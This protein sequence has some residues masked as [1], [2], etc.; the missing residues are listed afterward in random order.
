MKKWNGWGEDGVEKKIPDNASAVLRTLCGPGNPTPDIL[1]EDLVKRIPPS[2]I[3]QKDPCILV[4]AETRFHF[5]HGQSFPDW[6][7]MRTG[8]PARQITEGVAFP[9]TEDDIRHFIQLSK[10]P[11][12]VLIPYGGGSSVVGH[13]TPLETGRAC[14]TLSMSRMNRLLDLNEENHTATFQAGVLGPD[15]EAQLRGKGFTLGHFPQ[16]FEFS[17]LGGWIA[18]RSSGQQ[19]RCFGRMDQNFLGGTLLMDDTTLTLPHI[20]AS[21]AGP[22]IRHL[23][24]GSEGRMGILS[25]ATIRIRSIPETDR[26][27]A[28]FFPDLS[29]GLEA[30][31]HLAQ[32]PSSMSMLRLSNAA[33]TQT[34][35]ALSGKVVAEKWLKT[36][37]QLRGQDPR[38]SCLC[39]VGLTG[40][41]QRV[42]SDLS[43]IKKEARRHKGLYLHRSFEKKWKENRFLSAYARNTLWDLGYGVDT[44]ETALPWGRIAEAIPLVEQSIKQVD[45]AGIHVFTHL[46][47]VYETGSSMYTTYIF[48]LK[49]TPQAT[50]EK[51]SAM[52]SSASRTI[53]EL[54][55]TISHQHGVGTD[56]AP[57][58]TPEKDQKGM[59][60]LRS[61]FHEVD[62][63]SR[64]NPGKL[65][66]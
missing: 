54:G 4:D 2:R 13:L 20:P 50:L 52:K 43:R 49:E 59:D 29:S 51:W 1:I 33:E 39:L 26:V 17:S 6:V 14:M 18:T 12:W 55:G 63:E 8:Y 35:L 5:S 21:S 11:N 48:P 32:D 23:V 36:Y 40:E 57:Y 56:H 42:K 15:L 41:L 3:T 61:I 38:S 65:L 34:H 58:L 24:A 19:S 45:P 10:D 53:L 30:A 46:S 47:H 25:Q 44:L 28:F 7:F 66:K 64:F 16:S 27:Y 60:I 37:L 62:P 31:R 22:D 9:E